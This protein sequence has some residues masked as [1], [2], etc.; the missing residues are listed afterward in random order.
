MRRIALISLFLTLACQLLVAQELSTYRYY[1]LYESEDE[2]EPLI[3]EEQEQ[4]A[5]IPMPE[6]SGSIFDNIPNVV[7]DYRGVGY[8]Q[9]KGYINGLQLELLSGSYRIGL[10]SQRSYMG[11]DCY[12]TP[13]LLISEYTNT[14]VTLSTKGYNLGVT[15]SSAHNIGEQWSISND[16]YVRVGRDMHIR[17]VYTN[18]ARVNITHLGDTRRVNSVVPIL[19]G[20]YYPGL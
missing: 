6:W 10:D 8:Y 15:A 18:S 3:V 16:T 9:R 14:A 11:A 2:D 12:Y 13:T 1:K 20:R 4:S 5:V 17:G 7:N 19:L